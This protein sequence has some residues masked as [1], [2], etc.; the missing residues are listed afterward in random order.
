M[1]LVQAVGVFTIATVLRTPRWLH[2]RGAP[3]LGAESP[4]EGGGVRRA[5]APFH[6]VRLQQRATLRSP[7]LLKPEDDLLE[8]KHLGQAVSVWRSSRCYWVPA[9]R[10]NLAKDFLWEPRVRTSVIAMISSASATTSA[11]PKRT[12]GVTPWRPA[13]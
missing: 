7:I 5:R 3:W 9:A 6:V 10:Q 2:V 13:I 11:S 4:Q 1:M 8:R 12:Y